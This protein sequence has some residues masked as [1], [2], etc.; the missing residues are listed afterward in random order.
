M[1]FDPSAFIMNN[2]ELFMTLGVV[3]AIG[4][5]TLAATAVVIMLALRSDK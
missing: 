5:F 4:T 3:V 2:Q 1:T